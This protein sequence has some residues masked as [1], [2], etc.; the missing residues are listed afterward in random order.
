MSGAGKSNIYPRAEQLSVS[1]QHYREH[2]EQTAPFASTSEFGVSG[3]AVFA[4]GL[5]ESGGRL[6][7][8]DA[9][10]AVI[11]ALSWGSTTISGEGTPALSPQRGQSLIR[12]ATENGILNDTDNNVIDFVLSNTPVANGGDVYEPVDICPNDDVFPG[13][14]ANLPAGHKLDDN[15]NCVPIPVLPVEY[16]IIQLNEILPDPASPKN[17]ANDEFFIE[18]YNPNDQPVNVMGYKIL[19]GS[20]LS[21]V[22]TLPE[23]IISSHGYVTL[24]SSETKIS[25][26]NTGSKLQL[27]TP[28]GNAMG[29]LLQYG[30]VGADQVWALFG[31][32]WGL[33]DKPTPGAV[34]EQVTETEDAGIGSGAESAIAPCPSGKYRNPLTNRCR[35]IEADAAV[36]TACD[37]GEYRS[38]ETNRCRKL[39]SLAAVTV[40]ACDEGQERNPET[41]R[42]RKVAGSTTTALAPC[43]AGQERNTQTNRCRNATSSAQS[44]SAINQPEKQGLDAIGGVALGIVGL[45]AVSYGVY[46]WRSEI[47][48]HS[49]DWSRHSAKSN[50]YLGHE[51]YRHR[52]GNGDFRIW[53]D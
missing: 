21:S 53:G 46:E 15:G 25:L 4:A 1:K 13:N 37:D 7:I 11:D 40:N 39:A 42:C 32:A 52:P 12:N 35:N 29:G 20:N 38:P 47:A 30:P 41:N 3:D 18:L 16:P 36:L 31:D 34:N 24:Y 8:V 17:D 28:D 10:G 33:S 44:A 27:L 5:P 51:N 49:A 23:Y 9:G 22:Y 2:C 50:V 14:Q 26:S 43:K 45:A 6:R 19:S 48:L